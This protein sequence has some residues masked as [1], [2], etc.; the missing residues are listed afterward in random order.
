M[1]KI[2]GNTWL[3]E[4]ASCIGGYKADNDI[5]L[6]DSGN[7]DSS[8]R[9][10]VRG[11][12]TV[13]VKYVFNTHSHADHCGGNT[14]YVKKYNSSIISPE[15]EA[16]FLNYPVLEP[17]YLYGAAPPSDMINKFLCASPSRTDI[18]I[19]DEKEIFLELG[20]NKVKFRLIPLKGHSPNMYGIITP[21]NIAFIGD[22][23]L[24]KSFLDKHGLIFSFDVESHLNSLALLETLGA[25]GY[26]LSHGG[27]IENIDSLIDSN[28][29]SLEN[30]TA[31]ILDSLN[32]EPKSFD[33][34]HFYLYRK[35]ALKENLSLNI[36]NRSIIRAH[37][38][39]LHDSGEALMSAEEGKT[40]IRR[41][42]S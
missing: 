39:Y 31:A 23:L 42:T 15:I 20:N 10:A 22:A 13:N 2:K 36:L 24:G 5:L 12:D 18:V 19:K 3:Y 7:D 14:F 4:S 27:Y 37:I 33:D 17:V 16:C 25:E 6:V 9:K 21:D 30:A 28:R 40:L 38:Q 8:A 41:K 35:F 1:K 26:V 32:P 34:I 29:K 11:F